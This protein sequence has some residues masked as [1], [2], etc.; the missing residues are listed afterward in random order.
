MNL[1][2]NDKMRLAITMCA[3]LAHI[4]KDGIEEAWLFIVSDAMQNEK[5][6]K[7]FYYLSEQWI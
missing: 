1:K 4:S 3:A 5:L 7:V 2:E 6:R